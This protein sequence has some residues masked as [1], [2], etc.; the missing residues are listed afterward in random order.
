M[1][2]VAHRLAT[3]QNADVIFV[4]GDG[5]V[6]EAGNH[7]TLLQRGVVLSDG[8]LLIPKSIFAITLLRVLSCPANTSL[9]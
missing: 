1:I 3:V 5:E 7:R 2:V 4:T 6:L 9:T 8:E